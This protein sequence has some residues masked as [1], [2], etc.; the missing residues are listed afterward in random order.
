MAEKLSRYE[1]HQKFMG[2]TKMRD[3]FRANNNKNQANQGVVS[4]QEDSKIV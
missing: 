1:T 4:Q 2:D 3:S